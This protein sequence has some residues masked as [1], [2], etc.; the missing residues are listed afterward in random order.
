MFELV[1]GLEVH[2]QLNTK[3]KLFCSCKVEF[4]GTPNSNTCPTCLGLPGS[5]PVLNKDA[6]LKAMLFANGVNG[7]INNNSVFERKN[8]FYPDLPTGY[9]ISQLDIPIVEGGEL[10]IQDINSSD[11]IINLNR[12]HLETD[13]GKNIH[14]HNNSYVDLNRAGTP[15]LEIVTEPDFRS[16]EEVTSYLKQLH[17]IVKYLDISDANMQEGSFR[18]DVNISIR[19]KGDTNLYT[20]TEIKNLNSFKFIEKAIA[21]EYQRHVE[22]W[23]DG[24]YDKEIVQETRLFDTNSFVTKSMRSKEEAMDYR[25]FPDPDLKPVFIT[26]EMYNL[27]ANTPEMPREKSLRYIN[28]LNI[29]EKEVQRLVQDPELN[30]IFESL[31]FKGI[32]SSEI[33]TIISLLMVELQSYCNEF[34]IK[35]SNSPIF[36][37]QLKDLI[38]AVNSGTISINAAKKTLAF[39]LEKQEDLDLTLF[40]SL[41]KNSSSDLKID[42]V[43]NKLKLKQISN[44][45]TLNKFIEVVLISNKEDVEE[46]KAGKKKLFGSF[47]GKVMKETQ[48]QGNPQMINQLLKEK[49]GD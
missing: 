45:E 32:S 2:V 19:P 35:T 1:I 25:Y 43:L 12:A 47:V 9:Q 22:A 24:V 17:S 4:G 36:F 6:V 30:F 34:K 7:K 37:E 20:R 46:Y 16:I 28:E 33:K 44:K 8:Y 41:K 11:K 5:L 14:E 10:I 27:T 38:T 49:L 40:D 15:L 3:S 39:L 21:Y 42:F 26:E 31:I 29:N 13:A 48:G 23:E 18:C